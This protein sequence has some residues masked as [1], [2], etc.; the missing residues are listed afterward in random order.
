MQWT[1]GCLL[2]W[3]FFW[4]SGL[5]YNQDPAC[6]FSIGIY[7]VI[8]DYVGLPWASHVALAYACM[9]HMPHACAHYQ[10]NLPGQDVAELLLDQSLQL[11][12]KRRAAALAQISG[13]SRC[14]QVSS[15]HPFVSGGDRGCISDILRLLFCL[16][17][18]SN[19]CK[20]GAAS[21]I[22]VGEIDAF[23]NL[24]SRL[25]CMHALDCF[26]ASC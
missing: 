9:L 26:G 4:F 25:G 5:K 23:I 20:A 16:E 12:Q 13:V 8:L 2:L 24:T 21:E 11:R 10:A 17:I 14:F 7:W 3:R 18:L 15:D 6:R 1:I 19:L 22:P